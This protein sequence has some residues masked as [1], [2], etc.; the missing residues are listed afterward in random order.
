MIKEIFLSN[1]VLLSITSSEKWGERGHSPLRWTICGATA[2]CPKILLPRKCLDIACWWE[3][4]TFF[5]YIASMFGLFLIKLPL[6]Q[7]MRL[8]WPYFLT[9]PLLEGGGDTGECDRWFCEQQQ[10]D[11]AHNHYNLFWR[12]QTKAR[13]SNSF[14]TAWFEMTQLYDRFRQCNL[15]QIFKRFCCVDSLCIF[16]L[17]LYY[18]THSFHSPK[19]ECKTLH[20]FWRSSHKLFFSLT[21]LKVM[22]LSNYASA[23]PKINHSR[24]KISLL[25]QS[26]LIKK[27]TKPN[28]L[29]SKN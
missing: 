20:K 23:I 18:P 22:T 17:L 14:C 2:R 24:G 26:S 7:S 5:I 12:V 29:I 16:F 15:V 25:L 9:P 4:Q 11:K 3:E 27:K 1:D 19:R 28:T 21:L 6:S 10:P 8:L 13:I